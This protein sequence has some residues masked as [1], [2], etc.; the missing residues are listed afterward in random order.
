MPQNQTQRTV[1]V[2]LTRQNDAYHFEALNDTDNHLAMDGSPDIGGVNAGFRPM[3]LLLSSLGGCSAIDVVLILKKQKEPLED[4][5]IEVSGEREKV[6]GA[7][8]FKSIH[9]VYKFTG[10]LN[11]DK[12]RRAIE[13]S[14]TKYC[15]VGLMLQKACTITYDFEIA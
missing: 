4:L 5:V 14:M 13:L 12:V 7:T 11:P 10:N 3:Q 1:K 15:S 9:L 8:P 6:G 2:T